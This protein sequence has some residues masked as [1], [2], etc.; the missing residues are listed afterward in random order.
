MPSRGLGGRGLEVVTITAE[1]PLLSADLAG[2]T[3]A[4]IASSPLYARLE[5]LV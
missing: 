1:D 2:Q 3:L 5:C 4:G